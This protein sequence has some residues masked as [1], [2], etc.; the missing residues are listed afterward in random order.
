MVRV[1]FVCLGNICRSPLGEGILRHVVEQAGLGG[2][3]EVDSAGTGAWH[4]GEAPDPRSNAIAAQH[5][6]QAIA[7]KGKAE[8]E[9][10]SAHY[11]AK[12]QNKEIGVSSMW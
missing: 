11:K 9:V 6:A 2:R 10:L 4:A 7:A 1:L 3:I 5:Q 8:A 12:A